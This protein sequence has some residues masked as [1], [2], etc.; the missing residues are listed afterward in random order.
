LA[1]RPAIIVH[2]QFSCV[3]RAWGPACQRWQLAWLPSY[4]VEL[5]VWSH[6]VTQQGL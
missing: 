3:Q 4:L 1:Y 6:R 2:S 5:G